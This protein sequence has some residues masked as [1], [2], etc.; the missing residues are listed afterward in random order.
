MIE[1]TEG[2]ELSQPA[3]HQTPK[4]A[5]DTN[6]VYIRNVFLKYLETLYS[7]TAKGKDSVQLELRTIESILLTELKTSF[8]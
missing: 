8:E 3:Q 7:N 1:E 2:Q 6:M 5:V 4:I